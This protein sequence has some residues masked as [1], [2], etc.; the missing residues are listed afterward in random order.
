MKH[1]KEL[2]ISV[3]YYCET[4]FINTYGFSDIYKDVASFL[5]NADKE[6]LKRYVCNENDEE[7][8]DKTIADIYKVCH[9]KDIVTVVDEFDKY[10]RF[11]K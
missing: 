10:Y 3:C 11:M 1:S 5:V 2:G 6:R 9:R 4:S 7:Y 8:S